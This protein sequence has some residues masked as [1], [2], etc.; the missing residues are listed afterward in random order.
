MTRPADDRGG[1]VAPHAAADA[2]A[3]R[4]GGVGRRRA[5][6]VELR[7]ARRG[8]RPHRRRARRRGPA[9][10]RPAGPRARQHATPARSTGCCS[11]RTRP[12]GAR[13]GQRAPRPAR[14]RAHRARLGRAARSSRPAPRSPRSPRTTSERRDAGRPEI[15]DELAAP[16]PARSRTRRRTRTPPTCSTRPGTTGLP[17]GAAFR[18]RS[19][20]HSAPQLGAAH[21]AASGDDVF[22]TPAP[23]YTSTGTHTFP[24]PVLGA[25]ATY[26]AEPAF[27][28]ER[29]AR[30]AGG[31]GEHGVLRRAGDARP[32]ARA[33]RAGP[34]VPVAA[35]ADVRRLADARADDRRACSP[36]S[37][38]SGCGTS[39]G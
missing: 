28:A 4:A 16:R 19:L 32:A 9:A 7:G 17:K 5:P 2:R 29:T 8:D 23:V 11:A 26:V 21:A 14:D 35:G 31:R 24:L 18:H 27:D 13:A 10:G 20:A 12:G 6:R 33:A 15:V 36:A 37:R 34:R 3:R 39:T 1:A 25:G 22:Q 38:A 30:D